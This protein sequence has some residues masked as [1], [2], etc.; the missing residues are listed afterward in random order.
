MQIIISMFASIATFAV[1][2]YI[3]LAKIMKNFY[4]EKLSP[5]IVILNGSLVIN[6]YAAIFVYI[7]GTFS[8]Y[9]FV[10]KDAVSLGSAAMGGAILGLCMYA[11]Y[12]LTNMATL[13]KYPLSLVMVDILWG[14]FLV[15][16]ASVSMY[17][18]L[19]R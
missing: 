19:N 2:D 8:I 16:C 6:F 3:W 10:V 1:L 12:D 11:F 18:F 13:T 5:H 15:M 7:F 17:Y 14:T 9:Y 4:L